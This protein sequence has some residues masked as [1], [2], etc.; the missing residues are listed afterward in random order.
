MVSGSCRGF[1]WE[2]ATDK[3]VLRGRANI[4]M[5]LEANCQWLVSKFELGRCKIGGDA[6]R[7]RRC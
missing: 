7:K 1:N 2:V 6:R 3:E 4:D 5:F